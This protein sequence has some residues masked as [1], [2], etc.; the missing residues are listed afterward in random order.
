MRGE[1]VRLGPPGAGALGDVIAYGHHGRPVLMFPVERGEPTDYQERGVTDALH[2]LLEVGRVK[3]YCVEG[4]DSS[5]WLDDTLPLEERARRHGVYESW[6]VNQVV[7]WVRA[8]C[9]DGLELIAGGCSFGAYHAANFALK[10]PDLFPVALC[11]S[12]I[13]DISAVGWGE[14]GQEVY[15]NNPMHY[16]ANLHGEYLEWLRGLVR[17]VLVCGQGEAGDP[18]GALESTKRFGD[19]LGEKQIAH[20]LDLWGFDVSHDWPWWCAQAAFHLDRLT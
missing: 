4:Y 11:M 18:S 20:E 7:P 19:V 13:Y 9:G 14:R 17:L 3:L 2:R 16:V 8:D 5:S 15:F 10:R 6:I 1:R 12:G